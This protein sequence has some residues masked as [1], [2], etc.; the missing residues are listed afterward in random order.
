[1]LN[2]IAEFILEKILKKMENRIIELEKIIDLGGMTI[3]D[4]EIVNKDCNG[5]FPCT[6]HGFIEKGRVND[7]S[8]SM[9]NKNKYPRTSIFKAP[10]TY[11]DF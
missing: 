7:L 11:L 4:I 10:P 6:V 8:W 9:C 3:T 1:M 2:K 5:R